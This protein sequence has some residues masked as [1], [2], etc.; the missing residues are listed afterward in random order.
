MP[1]SSPPFSLDL[2]AHT[3]S[4][5]SLSKQQRAFNALVTQVRTRRERLG[6]WDTLTPQMQTVYLDELLPLHTV[7][8]DRSRALLL[9][10]DARIDDEQL[11]TSQ[12]QTISGVILGLLGELDDIG[13][14]AE[15]KRL[16]NRHASADYDE[17]IS[18]GLA[19]L[20]AD[21]EYMFGESLGDD[22][23][24]DSPDELARRIQEKIS[25]QQAREAAK[26]SA[27]Q[28]RK[29]ARSKAGKK[30][31]QAASQREELKAQLSQSLRE[32][33]RK[34]ASALHPDREPDSERRARKTELM[35]SLNQAYEK[36]DLLHMLELQIQLQQIDQAVLNEMSGE[37]LSHFIR[38]LG[39]QVAELDRALLEAESRFSQS[40]GI[41]IIHAVTP[42]Q[43]LMLMKSQ[44]HEL[45]L[46]VDA[47]EQD[48][49]QL[50]D[51]K[52]FKRWL[53]EQKKRQKEEYFF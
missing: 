12:R 23:D 30:P 42:E 33:Y 1:T 41:E 21:F 43:A 38:L 29:E 18:A 11:S 3:A 45:R 20:K 15:L 50:D 8:K 6:A 39:D 53:R 44:S 2:S 32:I 47:I 31:S 16:F 13:Q 27:R 37:R 17:E 19:E 46:V 10:L 34:L 7:L 9:A 24:L 4:N 5:A 26:E 35:Q 25:I 49:A 14:D 22:L 48:L 40:Y 51:P 52:A 28:E 36:Q